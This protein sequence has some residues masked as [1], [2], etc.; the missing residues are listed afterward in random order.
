ML[1]KTITDLKKKKKKGV[2]KMGPHEPWTKAGFGGEQPCVCPHGGR[3]RGR[4]G[5]TAGSG[6]RSPGGAAQRG[7]RRRGPLRPSRLRGRCCRPGSGAQSGR[8]EAASPGSGVGVPPAH[9]GSGAR[10]PRPR[11]AEARASAR[12]GASGSFARPSLRP[13]SRPSALTRS[14][15]HTKT[16]SGQPK[17]TE[18]IC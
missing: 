6:V 12:K 3:R 9:A 8:R 13:D 17:G 11:V 2:R 16:N 15:R 7:G 18:N 1:G 5:R 10:A 14:G 4:R